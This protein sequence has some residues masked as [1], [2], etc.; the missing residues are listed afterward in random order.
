MKKLVVKLRILEKG[1]EARACGCGA[2]VGDIMFACK[3]CSRLWPIKELGQKA[4]CYYC[5]KLEQ[6]K[7][8][9]KR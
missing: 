6:E 2:V 5:E 8:G 7:R 9:A 3:R 4:L 1:S